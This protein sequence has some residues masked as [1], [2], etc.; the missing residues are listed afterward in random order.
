MFMGAIVFPGEPTAA[1]APIAS[2]APSAVDTTPAPQ[3]SLRA[4]AEIGVDLQQTP[5]QSEAIFARHGLHESSQR[6]TVDAQWRARLA[7]NAGERAEW[8]RL[9][10]ERRGLYESR[11]GQS[12]ARAMPPTA[13]AANVPPLPMDIAEYALM[14]VELEK[15]P[16]ERESTYERHGLIDP[17]KRRAVD[18]AFRARFAAIPAEHAQWQSTVDRIRNDWI[19]L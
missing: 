8:V 14:C 18:E 19:D 1:P 5:E 3:L 9:C 10:A 7:A 17:K 4:Y 13:P 16:M 12:T 15:K 6:S 2:P 11:R